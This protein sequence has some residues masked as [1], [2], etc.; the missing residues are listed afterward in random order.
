M[1]KGLGSLLG[2]IAKL[3]A[4]EIANKFVENMAGFRVAAMGDSKR[5]CPGNI[6]AINRKCTRV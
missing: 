3:L 6:T 2:G 1:D 5:N 4:Q